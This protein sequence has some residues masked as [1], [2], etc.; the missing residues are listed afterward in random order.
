MSNKWKAIGLHDD[1]TAEVGQTIRVSAVD[2]N[3]VPTAWEAVDAPDKLSD[4]ENDIFYSNRTPVATITLDDLTFD[5]NGN[6]IYEMDKINLPENGKFGFTVSGE[7]KD[8]SF[9]GTEADYPWNEIINTD[10]G[11]AWFQY[12]HGI[13]VRNGIDFDAEN[14]KIETDKCKIL[15]LWVEYLAT[16]LNFTLEIIDEKKLPNSVVDA[17]QFKM[18]RYNEETDDYERTPYTDEI[19]ITDRDS[20]EADSSVVV[21]EKALGFENVLYVPGAKGGDVVENT[22]VNSIVF[23]NNADSAE[24]GKQWLTQNKGMYV[25]LGTNKLRKIKVC[26]GGN[27][28]TDPIYNVILTPFADGSELLNETEEINFTGSFV[29]AGGS[30]LT[31][32]ITRNDDGTGNVTITK[33]M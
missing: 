25:P 12:E 24:V 3:G 23:A 29:T 20:V 21:L 4:F 28:S 15:L 16:S 31:I 9:S 32:V 27:T 2:E 18:Q 6:G 13:D 1:A 22:V 10:F 30:F 5:E 11:S 7:G 26:C 14:N 19:V 8:S 33:K 17:P